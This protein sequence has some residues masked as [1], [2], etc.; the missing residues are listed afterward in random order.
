M[1]KKKTGEKE[2]M[3]ATETAVKA[4]RLELD[5][6]THKKLRIRAAT[7]DM[8]MAEYVRGLVKD[9]LDAKSKSGK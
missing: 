3:Q 9:D 8:S 2:P 1:A 4:V 6:D 5:L 7:M